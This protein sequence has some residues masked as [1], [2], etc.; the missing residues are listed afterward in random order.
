MMAYICRMYPKANTAL[1]LRKFFYVFGEH[2]KW[3]DRTPVVLTKYQKGW[4]REENPADIFPII[5]PAEPTINATN[6]V[7]ES[8]KMLLCDELKRASA[9]FE[10]QL[11]EY[12]KTSN[13]E[14]LTGLWERLIEKP[15]FFERYKTY[16]QVAV[17]STTED[18]LNR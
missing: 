15:D 11:A 13:P 4:R 12:K 17:Y 6:K 10:A 18:Q 8:T 3:G 1:A 9:I 2:W 14:V 7:N 16:I 5:T